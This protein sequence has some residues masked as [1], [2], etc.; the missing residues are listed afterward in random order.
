MYIRLDSSVSVTTLPQRFLFF[1]DSGM[2][3]KQLARSEQASRATALD[4]KINSAE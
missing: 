2:P 1:F 4:V 3:L